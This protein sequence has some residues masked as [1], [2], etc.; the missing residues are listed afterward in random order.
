MS[1][2]ET[3]RTAAARCAG[4]AARG[5]KAARGAT[6]KRY[7]AWAPSLTSSSATRLPGSP[8]RNQ[9]RAS[10]GAPAAS[11]AIAIQRGAAGPPARA[12]SDRYESAKTGSVRTEASTGAAASPSIG[13]VGRACPRA[14][15]P[16]GLPSDLERRVGQ[17]GREDRRRC[18]PR[19]RRAGPPI[20]AGGAPP[21]AP[22]P[23]EL[24]A[25][26]AT[27]T[28][29]DLRTRSP[30]RQRT[31]RSLDADPPGRAIGRHG[32]DVGAADPEAREAFVERRERHA[33]V[34]VEDRRDARERAGGELDEL[35]LLVP[36]QVDE[37]VGEPLAEASVAQSPDEGAEGRAQ[38]F[39][40]PG[41][42]LRDPCR[43]SAW[44]APA[45]ARTLATSR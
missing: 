45:S 18:R 39:E 7:V 25:S 32:P 29:R 30:A 35:D 37:A 10:S 27:S 26:M 16:A 14:G 41:A 15:S 12:T 28:R 38:P 20:A 40:R 36:V 42:G 3:S 5:S 23:R 33:A 43:P 8:T 6:R 17:P 1:A 34:V 22:R 31:G 21:C 2:S 44:T 11:G 24:E 4:S 19:P 13:C 9:T